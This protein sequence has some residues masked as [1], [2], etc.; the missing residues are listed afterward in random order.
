[1]T[2]LTLLSGLFGALCM[3]VN[4]PE[5]LMV[6]AYIVAVFY[7]FWITASPERAQSFLTRLRGRLV[8]GSR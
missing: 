5:P 3:L 4:V 2:A 7:W 6:M 1:M 8:R